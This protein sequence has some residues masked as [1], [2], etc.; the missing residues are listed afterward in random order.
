MKY[1]DLVELCR[2]GGDPVS[3]GEDDGTAGRD[4][5]VGT[6][7]VYLGVNREWSRGRFA[8]DILIDGAPGWV[9]QNEIVP[10]TCATP[11]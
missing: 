10:V 9:W 8:Y 11:S 1:G 2:E 4:F 6:L 3:I 5:P 7:C